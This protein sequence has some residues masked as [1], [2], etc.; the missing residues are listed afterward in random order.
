[1]WP[2]KINTPPLF[3]TFPLDKQHCVVPFLSMHWTLCSCLYTLVTIYYCCYYF[4]TILLLDEC[5][6]SIQHF[7]PAMLTSIR[8][9][10]GMCGMEQLFIFKTFMKPSLCKGEAVW[11][12]KQL[13][14]DIGRF[15]GGGGII[16]SLKYSRAYLWCQILW[17]IPAHI[18]QKIVKVKNWSIGSFFLI[19]SQIDVGTLTCSCSCIF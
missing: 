4:L 7:M 3:C 5:L 17:S 8:G 18:I 16:E 9:E 15:V 2:V 6:W 19:L 1:M 11:V 10:N 14:I 12:N 13:F